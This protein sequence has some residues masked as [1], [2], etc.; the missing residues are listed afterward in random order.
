[1]LKNVLLVFALSSVS[2]L[3][4]ASEIDAREASKQTI[5]LQD[6]S[7]AY[8]FPSGKMAVESRYGNAVSVKE[9]T[10]LKASNGSNVTMVGNEVAYLNDLLHGD[11][12]DRIH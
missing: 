6:G 9:G 12:G 2:L 10:A 5:A 8:V 7:I 1:M 11:N 4:M 3:A